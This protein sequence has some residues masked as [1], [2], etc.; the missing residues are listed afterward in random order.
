MNL[1][2]VNILFLSILPI[3]ESRTRVFFMAWQ[4]KDSLLKR[5]TQ[6]GSFYT[7]FRQGRF[8]FASLNT[9]QFLGALNDNIYKLL[10]IFFL[11]RI[12]S[13]ENAGRI[14]ALAG[15]LYVTPFL[16]FSSASGILADRFSKQR[17]IQLLKGIEIFILCLAF[18]AFFTKSSTACYLLLFLLASHS[19]VFGPSKYGIIPEIVERKQITRANGQLTSLTYLAVILGTFLASFLTDITEGNFTLAVGAC[20]LF[21]LV[22]F[23][24]TFGIRPT[25]AQRSIQKIRFLFVQEILQTIK[26]AQKIPLLLPALFGSAYF[27]FL[28]AFT[29]LN[30]IPFAIESL[31]LSEYAGGYLFLCTALGIVLGSW[32]TSKWMKQRLDI[33]STCLL[34]AGLCL[35]YLCLWLFSRSLFGSIFFLILIGVLGGMFVVACDTYIQVHSPSEKRGQIVGTANFLSFFGVLIASLLLFVFHGMKLRASTGFLS[36]ALITALSTGFLILQLLETFL[37]FFARQAFF[38]KKPSIQDPFDMRHCTRLFLIQ[39]WH[40][41]LLWTVLTHSTRCH[42]VIQQTPDTFLLWVLRLSPHVHFLPEGLSLQEALQIAEN[43]VPEDSTICLFST[44]PLPSKKAFN[45]LSFLHTKGDLCLLFLSHE[46][47]NTV[48]IDRVDRV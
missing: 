47:K 41:A 42:F 14:A 5:W 32:I 26:E 12:G 40:K 44:R 36:I 22:G 4:K 37:P 13:L 39:S 9:A 45:P 34:G 1:V 17:L 24:A 18:F 2:S 23:L 25:E 30:V 6:E 7:R 35:F 48:V 28:G 19:A 29:Q 21:S 43:Q 46:M 27:L 3:S 10:V 15:T 38:Y 16:L 20:F 31:H 33:H 8:S 11:L